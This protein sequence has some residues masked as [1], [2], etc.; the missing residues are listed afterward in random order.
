[1]ELLDLMLARVEQANPAINAV[2]TLDAEL[3]REAARAA[4]D[5][6]PVERGVLHGLPMT[7]KDA[8]E[9]VG[10]TASCGLPDFVQHRPLRDADA[11]ARLRAAG[12]IPFGKSNVPVL[13]VRRGRSLRGR[14]AGLCRHA[15]AGR[16][17][18]G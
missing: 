12:A 8:F 16:R 10:M 2:V 15:A 5:A 4:D 9:V 17:P 1:M 13:P 11:V 18:G 6:A 3:A 14:P 7:I